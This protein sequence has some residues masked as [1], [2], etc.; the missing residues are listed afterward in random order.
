[1]AANRNLGGWRPDETGMLYVLKEEAT[2]NDDLGWTSEEVEKAPKEFFVQVLEQ[3]RSNKKYE[4]NE[5]T[6][7]LVL[8]RSVD[9]TEWLPYFMPEDKRWMKVADR[10]IFDCII[11]AGMHH[12]WRTWQETFVDEET[13]EE[14]LISRYET[15]NTPL[16]ERNEEEEKELFERV[17]KTWMIGWSVLPYHYLDLLKLTSFDYTRL[18]RKQLER[19]DDFVKRGNIVE[20][21]SWV[22]DEI[23]WV[24][25]ELGDI[26]RWGE[27]YLGY[28]IDKQK[29][30]EY[31]DFAG[32]TDENPLDDKEEPDEFSDIFLFT[33]K[34]DYAA[35]KSLILQYAELPDNEFGIYSSVG[36]IMNALVGTDPRL[37]KYFG[38]VLYTS[39]KDGIFS[40]NTELRCVEP[41]VYAIKGKF[42]ALDV[43][44]E[45]Q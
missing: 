34:G 25:Q 19:L 9:I 31:Y 20:E 43:R 39:E 22:N 18:L 6:I 27:E 23:K 10:T 21:D 7:R 40:F 13:K 35:L 32:L 38:Y 37:A 45:M 16:F 24:C 42:P 44:V 28:F 33:V 30:K 17:C 11:L 26:Y 4:D 8:E 3:L 36:K 2:L 12:S 14:V 1:M 5:S 29:A 15:S 41:L